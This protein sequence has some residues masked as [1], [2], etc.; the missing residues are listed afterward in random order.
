[1]RIFLSYRREDAAGQSGRLR[2]ALV[3]RFG[4]ESVFHDVSTI[5]PGQD[6]TEALA[7]AINEC[8]VML[9]VIGP[10]WA[11]VLGP[12]D[13]PRLHDPQDYVR[14]EV[15]SALATSKRT[16]PVLVGGAV[17]PAADS[18]PSDL[19]ALLTRQSIE[20]RDTSWQADLDT[21]L[22]SLQTEPGRLRKALVAGRR[23]ALV[24]I[25]AIVL[26]VGAWQSWSA[27]SRDETNGRVLPSCFP[28]LASGPG[29]TAVNLVKEPLGKFRES[30]FE[31]RAAGYRNLEPGR[32]AL[33]TRVKMT[34]LTTTDEAQYHADWT[35]DGIVVDSVLYRLSCFST[36]A[37]DVLTGPGLSGEAL[38]GIETPAEPRGQIEIAVQQQ[39]R[40]VISSPTE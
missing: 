26:S 29:W 3:G 32:W 25:V 8:D 10:R 39:P 6:F 19:R 1:M 38:I 22:S 14:L 2:D 36:V 20:L 23:P 28:Q 35:Y 16:V 11:T 31:A 24:G 33:Q 27:F 7:A 37:G 15:A 4:A 30:L 13:S 21:L 17:L 34:N 12:N 9:V 5:R 40:I 18:L